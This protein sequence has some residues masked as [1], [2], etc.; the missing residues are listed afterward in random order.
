MNWFKKH[1]N[2]TYLITFIL[3]GLLCWLFYEI[4]Q[5]DTLG[6]FAVVLYFVVAGWVLKNKRR[7]L[8]WLLLS[9]Y[10]LA[11]LWLTNSKELHD[12]EKLL[13]QKQY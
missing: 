7:S 9:P 2:L 13:K 4:L 1:L 8:W 6:L 5:N 3:C 11:P 12:Y 10:L